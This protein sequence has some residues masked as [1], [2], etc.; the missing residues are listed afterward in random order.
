M[1]FDGRLLSGIE[2]LAA[3][4]EAGSFVRAAE[5]LGL[6]QS[7]VSR[8]VARLERR[9]GVRLFDRHRAHRGRAKLLPTG[10]A[11][12]LRHRGCRHPSCGLGRGRARPA[13]GQCRPLFR[14]PRPRPA[15]RQ[16]P[17]SPSGAVA[18][19]LGA[20]PARRPRRGWF[21]CRP[22]LRRARAIFSHRPTVARDEGADL[23]RSSLSGQARSPRAP[24]RAR[25]RTARM[26]S[27]RRPRHRPPVPLGVSP[28]PAENP[29]RSFRATDREQRRNHA[30]RLRRR[31]RIAQILA[32]GTDDLLKRGELVELFPDWPGERFPLY[33]FY[34]SRHVP[35]AKLRAF[36]DFVVHSVADT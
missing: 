11:A 29:G 18:G 4:V 10:Q 16:I 31:S 25:G 34:L 33:M 6:T 17:G 20:R 15:P 27:L 21:R 13:T 26:H 1:A 3:V 12:P 36:V 22:A 19:D 8:A 24:A 30:R 32:L 5:S 9:V 23:C 14:T 7:G 28:G 35:P 2:V